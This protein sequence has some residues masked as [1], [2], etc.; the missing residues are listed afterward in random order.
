MLYYY[1]YY[2][3]LMSVNGC[4][5]DINSIHTVYCLHCTLI[6]LKLP[7]EKIY[8]SAKSLKVLCPFHTRGVISSGYRYFVKCPVVQLPS[9]VCMQTCNTVANSSIHWVSSR[10]LK[11]SKFLP[12]KHWPSFT[13]I[14]PRS[15]FLFE[16]F[17]HPFIGMSP[18]CPFFLVTFHRYVFHVV[19]E[20]MVHG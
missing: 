19:T 20:G 4:Y 15:V 3:C 1:H 17:H 18:C 14:H 2:K 10:S 6:C 11:C 7:K 16:P 12:L 9:D 8:V 13:A 5:S